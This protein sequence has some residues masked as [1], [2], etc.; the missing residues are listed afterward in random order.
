MVDTEIAVGPENSPAVGEKSEERSGTVDENPGM[1][2]KGLFYYYNVMSKAMN[3]CDVDVLINP[4]DH[5]TINWRSEI[6]AELIEKQHA[7]GSWVNQNGSFWENDPILVTS[8]S[9][10]TLQYALDERR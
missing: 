2:S 4:D 3:V 5:S 6:V 9:V 8:Y 10:L 7:D 1:G